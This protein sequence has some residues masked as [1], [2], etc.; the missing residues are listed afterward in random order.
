ME[1]DLRRTSRL[2]KPL[3]IPGF[4]YDEDSV[5]I[6]TSTSEDSSDSRQ[7]RPGPDQ[8]Y[9]PASDQAYY[10]AP[11][12]PSDF[13]NSV[14]A[15]FTKSE[16]LNLEHLPV[17]VN[18]D[19]T[20]ENLVNSEFVIN[21]DLFLNSSTDISEPENKS[22]VTS[23]VNI[24]SEGSSSRHRSSTRYDFL[25]SKEPFLSVST[26]VRTDTSD[27]PSSESE[28][29]GNT[30]MLKVCKC[31]VG[32]SCPQCAASGGIG[33]PGQSESSQM[34]TLMDKMISKLDKMSREVSSLKG[35][36]NEY[37]D[38]LALVENKGSDNSDGNESS[39]S[40]KGGTRKKKK[41]SGP[42]KDKSKKVRMA[43][44]KQ[45]QLEVLFDKMEDKGQ[46]D[47]ESD[48]EGEESSEDELNVRK[49]KKKLSSKQRKKCEKKV[50]AILGDIGSNF[51]DEEDSPSAADSSGTDSELEDKKSKSRR[52]KSGAKV[53]KRPVVRTE[54]WP[55]TIANEDDGDDVTSENISLAKFL[56]CF[57]YIMITC[58]KAEAAGRP[59]LLYAVTSVLECLPWSEARTFHNMV[60]TK[61]EQGRIDWATDF[62]ELAESFLNKKV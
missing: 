17:F 3:R 20:S 59:V 55:H 52:V 28:A 58:E 47:T 46:K 6:L 48:A 44:D 31:P 36:V 1:K 37:G 22:A 61:I 25:N 30:T 33:E 43:E 38:R 42:V 2:P 50:A 15:S 24:G 41:A 60:M 35:I 39:I 57:A 62:T 11:A 18:T 29:D 34:M 49:V 12:S 10:Q 54:L 45:R 32:R 51:P 14:N 5:R 4:Y 19:I 9:S 53:K 13:N 21:S 8:A 7:R 26:S 23:Q 56:S 40:Q 27:M 16:L